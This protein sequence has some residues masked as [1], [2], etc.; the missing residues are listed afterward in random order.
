MS[1][2]ALAIIRPEN[3]ANIVK[4][5]PQSYKDNQ[6]SHDRCLKACQ[7]L[8]ANIEKQGMNDQLDQQ[9]ATFIDKARRTVKCMNERRSAVTKLFDEVRSAYTGLENDI[10]PTKRDTV[11]F[12]LQQLRDKYAA[13]KREEEQRRQREETERKSR[14]AARTK[15]LTDV[16]DDLK[17]KYADFVKGSLDALAAINTAITLDNFEASAKRIKEV[18]TALPD[19]FTAGLRTTIPLPYGITPAEATAMEQEVLQ[20]L[21]PKLKEQYKFDI[22][23]N[24]DYITDRLPSKRRE[25]ENIAKASGEEAERLRREKEEREK[26]EAARRAEEQQHR[27]EEESKLAEQ[28][29]QQQGMQNLFALQAIV[30]GGSYAPKTKVTKKI[31]LLNPEGILPIISMWFANEGC[32][33]TVEVLAKKFKFAVTYCE[34]LANKEGTTI[35]DESIEYIDEVKAK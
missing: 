9:A 32:K 19:T 1:T 28:H 22:E 33:M 29:R 26:A 14:E 17:R 27:A 35:N 5:A 11:P 12:R 4:A 34:K 6:Q 13:K 8:L 30:Q 15:Y 7:D 3:I 18:A 25:L 21:V 23:S 24:R 10:D 2:T 31:N 20:T 16:E